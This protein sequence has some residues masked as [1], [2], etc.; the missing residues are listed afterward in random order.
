[1]TAR[2]RATGLAVPLAALAMIGPF[3]IDTYLPSFP[4]IQADLQVSARADAADALGLSAHVRDHDAVSRNALRLVRAASGRAR[5]S[6]RVRDRLARLRARARRSSSSS[7]FARIQGLSAGA[8][9]VVGRAIIRDSLE[10]HAAQRLMS[11]VTMI[12]G[13]APAIAPDH[14]RLAAGLVRL[15]FRVRFSGGLRRHSS[16][17]VQGAASRNAAPERSAAIQAGTAHPQLLDARPQPPAFPALLCDRAQFLRLLHLHR[18]GAGVHLR[19]TRPDRDRL[20]LAVRT[21][22]RGCDDRRVLL[23]PARGKALPA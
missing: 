11:L 3:S 23:G 10:G 19:S 4:A 20:S 7:Y 17:R 12:F 22:H 9:I 8:G 18:L 6:S 15:A 14:R 21:G 5:E 13:V 16:A 1:M 2:Q